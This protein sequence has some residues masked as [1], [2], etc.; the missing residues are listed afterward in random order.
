MRIQGNRLPRSAGHVPRVARAHPQVGGHGLGTKHRLYE[1][2]NRRIAELE[3]KL[4]EEASTE[5]ERHVQVGEAGPREHEKP[6]G[7]M[8][9]LLSG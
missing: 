6:V 2:V 4:G 8:V 1:W 7:E 3:A 5:P 9:P